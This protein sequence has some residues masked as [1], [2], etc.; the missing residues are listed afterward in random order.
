M[1]RVD[2]IALRTVLLLSF[3]LALTLGVRFGNFDF[4]RRAIADLENTAV[5]HAHGASATPTPVPKEQVWPKASFVRA[6]D[7]PVVKAERAM[8]VVTPI[9]VPPI[10]RLRV[11][12]SQWSA[13]LRVPPGQ[14][15]GIK[16][17]LGRI[18]V[19]RDG[20]AEGIL[21]RNPTLVND[22]NGTTTIRPLASLDHTPRIVWFRADVRVLRFMSLEKE[23]EDIDVLWEA[24]GGGL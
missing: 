6:P 24:S 2:G 19:E 8:P 11:V 13:P 22:G 1:T 17:K 5:S 7:L 9:P 20:E 21:Y 16:F 15:V 18:R 3:A 4:V 14:R 10:I 12:P 23:S